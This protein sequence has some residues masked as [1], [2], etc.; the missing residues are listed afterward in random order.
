MCVVV[1]LFFFLKKRHTHTHARNF[2][3]IGKL[4]RRRRGKSFKKIYMHIIRRILSEGRY[5]QILKYKNICPLI[6]MDLSPS[7]IT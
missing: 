1:F 6:I 2:N 5:I 3:I 7:E 4:Y